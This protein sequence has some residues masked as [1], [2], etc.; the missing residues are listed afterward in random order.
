[1]SASWGTLAARYPS[2][3]L[4]NQSQHDLF[5]LAVYGYVLRRTLVTGARWKATDSSAL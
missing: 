4:L 1:M 5:M 2:S 3:S